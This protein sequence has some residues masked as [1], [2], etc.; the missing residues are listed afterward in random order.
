MRTA[1]SH[2][3]RGVASRMLQH[4]IQEAAARGY[5]TLSLETGSMEF[6][7]AVRR[8]YASNGFVSCGPFGNYKLDPNS[9]FMTK[10]ISELVPNIS[11]KPK[12]LR[13]S[14]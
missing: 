1:T 4:Q 3:R 10:Q 6:F 2:L 9:V 8:L 7:E 14:A 5:S 11:I 12:P 13:G